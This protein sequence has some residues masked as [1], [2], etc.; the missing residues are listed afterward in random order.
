[1]SK[2]RFDFLTRNFVLALLLASMAVSLT[3]CPSTVAY[4][5]IDDGRPDNH[6]SSG[7]SGG[8]TY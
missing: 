6:S 5:T 7:D 2:F 8:R 4:K 3:A 1:M